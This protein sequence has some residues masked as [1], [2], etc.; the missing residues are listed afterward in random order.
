MVQWVKDLAVSLQQ[1]GSLMQ[2][3]F[4]PWPRNFHMLQEQPPKRHLILVLKLFL[5]SPQIK[6]HLIAT[7]TG[8]TCHRSLL[9]RL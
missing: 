4:H 3:E 2:Y 5:K 8:Q 6:H 9:L 1:P 7:P